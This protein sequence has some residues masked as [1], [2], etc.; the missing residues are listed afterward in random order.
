MSRDD[1][2]LITDL[3]K[4]NYKDLMEIGNKRIKN[5]KND[6]GDFGAEFIKETQDRASKKNNE[7][8]QID[9]TM[10][11]N[12]NDDDM[13]IEIL[14]NN[15]IEMDNIIEE[16]NDI[17]ILSNNNQRQRKIFKSFKLLNKSKQQRIAT[18]KQLR[19]SPGRNIKSQFIPFNIKLFSNRK[20]IN[21]IYSLSIKRAR[22]ESYKK[23][24]RNISN[25]V[26]K[27]V[28]YEQDF[29]AN[30]PFIKK[31]MK[32]IEIYLKRK[33]EQRILKE[34]EKRQQQLLLFEKEKEKDKKQINM[35]QVI[36]NKKLEALEEEDHTLINQIVE[37][38]LN[39][40]VGKHNRSNLEVTVKD[41]LTLEPGQWLNDE[42]MNFYMSLLQDRNLKRRQNNKKY[43]RALFMNTFFFTK[44]SSNSYNYKSVKRWTKKAKLVKKGCLNLNNIFELDKF[45]FPVHVNSIHWCCGCIN[46]SM[47]KF[48]Y[49]DSMNGSSSDFFRIIRKYLEDE[50]K[51]KLKCDK[52]KY[53]LNLNE[54]KEDNNIGKYPQQ[55]NG[56]DCG[57]FTS[58]CAD[59]ISDDLYPDYAQQNMSYFRER[60]M[61]EIVQGKTLDF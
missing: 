38:P 57:V 50:W 27:T 47:K 31:I 22:I 10:D 16:D 13:S 21:N 3:N 52:N 48:E 11:D 40:V 23:F 55:E 34:E 60:M 19:K 29:D 2:I 61:V 58:K 15:K 41:I 32:N 44:L 1:G 24:N 35:S 17:Q 42:V 30:K 43:V 36:R 37:L 5:V 54:W 25:D 18:L 7:K 56:V 45:I 4:Q 39:K 9:L 26:Y 46:F 8:I 49:Y 53:D 59:W 6:F 12:D 20:L 28:K 14:N 51:D 33:Q